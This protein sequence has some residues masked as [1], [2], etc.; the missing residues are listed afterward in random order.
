MFRLKKA[1]GLANLLRIKNRGTNVE[2]MGYTRFL[3]P[4]SIVLGN[5]VRIGYGCFFFGKGGIHVGDNTI[6]S[7]NVT[8]YSS[9]HNFLGDMIPYDSSH[10]HKPVVIGRGVWIGMGVSITPGVNI[11]DGAIIGM[12]SV[13]SKNVAQGAIVVGTGQREITSRNIDKF[14]QLLEA[15]QIYSVHYP[16]H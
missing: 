3:N 15:N 9:N 5:N 4:E 8:I 10:I 6:I 16:K 2:V 11:G 12:G 13:I 14:Y 7:R 1:W